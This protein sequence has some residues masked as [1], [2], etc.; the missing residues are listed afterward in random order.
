MARMETICS[1]VPS[2]VEHLQIRVRNADEIKTILERLGHLTSVTFEYSQI[3]TIQREEF[4]H[5][6]SFLQR[7]SSLWNSQNALHV[8]LEAEKAAT[9]TV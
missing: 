1:I 7:A 3:L 8:W 4:V 9:T 5:C 2:N 6:L